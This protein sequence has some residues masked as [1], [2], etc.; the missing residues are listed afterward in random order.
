MFPPAPA[1]ARCKICSA[2]APLFGAV[3]FHRSCVEPAGLRLAPSGHLVHYHR[4]GTC[5]FLFTA[6]LDE[7]TIEDFAEHVYNAGYAAMDPE[8]R[9]TRPARMARMVS[10]AFAASREGL[11]VLDYGGGDGLLASLLRDAAFD[12]ESWDPF[13][14]GGAPPDRR[15]DLITCFEVLEHVPDPHGTAAAIAGLLSPGGML[16]FSTLL[17]PP[18]IA[19]QSMGWWYIGPRNGHV[20]LFSAESL[21]RLWAALGMRMDTLS[22]GLHCAGLLHAA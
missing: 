20:S 3:D 2:A 5:G 19:A 6:A 17:Q 10:A 13:V 11:R 18:D 22:E 21:S 8:Y 1:I 9:E 12:A 14:E 15:Y 4:C 7:W 16:L